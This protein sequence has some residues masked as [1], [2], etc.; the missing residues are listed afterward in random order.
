[1]SGGKGLRPGFRTFEICATDKRPNIKV[2]DGAE[3]RFKSRVSLLDPPI[4]RPEQTEG[5]PLQWAEA[6]NPIEVRPRPFVGEFAVE[7]RS[8][9][10]QGFTLVRC[11]D[12][13]RFSTAN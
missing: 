2:A 1:M 12:T 9:S 10:R 4:E 13:L 8:V 6:T 5:N 7:K 11:C 3:F